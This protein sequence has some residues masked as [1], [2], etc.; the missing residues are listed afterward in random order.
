MIAVHASSTGPTFSAPN[1]TNLYAENATPAGYTCAANRLAGPSAAL[2]YAMS[3]ADA[4]LSGGI[5]IQASV[6]TTVMGGSDFSGGMRRTQRG[7]WRW[8]AKPLKANKG[9]WMS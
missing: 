6:G 4:F 1:G 9:R 8:R 7:G 2:T 5:A 3:A